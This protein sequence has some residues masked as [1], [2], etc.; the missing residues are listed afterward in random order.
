[1]ASPDDMLR[2]STPGLDLAEIS[3]RWTSIQDPHRFVLR[4]SP[5]IVAYLNALLRHPDDA[6][7]V[8]QEFFIKF[9]ERGLPRAE[10]SRG[11]FRDYLK[12][13][14][15]N[16]ALSHLR[17]KRPQQSDP[18]LLAAVA[19]GHETTADREMCRAW[20][21]CALDKMW[22]ALE[23]HQR[24]NPGNFAYDVLKVSLEHAQEDSEQQAE[25]VSRSV[26]QPLS[27]VAFRKQR[28]RARQLAAEILLDEV[29]STLEDPSPANLED[30]LA[31][32]DLLELLRGYLA[33]GA[34]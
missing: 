4:Y 9:V 8:A 1:M 11:R 16:A 17:K 33:D 2:A 22:R 28:S 29:R 7:D 3:T 31:D 27:A 5:A 32:L 21:A 34:A 25:R 13:A 12:V 15:R 10:Q 26:G 14:V 19:A 30:E 20:K 6:H 23:R 24:D 18:E